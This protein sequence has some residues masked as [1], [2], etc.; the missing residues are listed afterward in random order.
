VLYLL[1]AGG[2][3]YSLGAVIQDRFRFRFDNVVWHAFV[4]LGE[5][6]H[7]TAVIHLFAQGDVGS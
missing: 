2:I 5:S 6:L 3:A 7:W 4:V 1:L